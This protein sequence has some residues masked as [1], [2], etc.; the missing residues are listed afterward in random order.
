[1]NDR[2]P[3]RLAAIL[4]ADVAEYSRL[5]GENEDD[6]HR[7]LS[8]ALDAIAEITTRHRGRVMHYAGDA[9]LAM[10]DAVVD[11]VACACAIQGKL[12]EDN[13]GLP[14]ERQVHFRIGVNLGD[15]IED[16]SD[17][18]GDGVNV[19]ARLESLAE[20]G[21]ICVSEAVYG[22]LGNKLPVRG[23]FLGE[24]NVKNISQPVRVYS[25]ALTDEAVLG[26]PN[27]RHG[28]GYMV[29]EVSGTALLV[30]IGTV[31]AI[32]LMGQPGSPGASKQLATAG[33]D[34]PSI[35]VLPF[36]NLSG[37]SEQDYF[38]EGLAEDLLTDLSKL[39]GLVVIARTSSFAIAGQALDVGEIGRRLDIRYL[40]EGR[41]RKA[42]D[43]LRV[44]AQLIDTQSDEHV[45]AERWDRPTDDLFS[46]QDELA[47][48]IVAVLNDALAAATAGL[49]VRR[50][51]K[52]S[53]T[54]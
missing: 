6:T 33:G 36:D 24:R 37:D 14:E 4:Y 34:L 54:W 29:A 31:I 23:Q 40:V 9:V 7:R 28:P 47:R 13:V 53:L 20:P 22:A 19:A 35:A 3:R 44:N 30:I 46:V 38:A 32:I 18:Y 5:T 51:F 21:G 49:S 48:H 15:V 43:R 27:R 25:I 17:I 50:N 10:F 1:M 45:W 26:S 16:D 41:V 39:R 2:L 11:A 52:S 42:T 12:Q 8:D